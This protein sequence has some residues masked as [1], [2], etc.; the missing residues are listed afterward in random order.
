MHKTLSG[1]SAPN[2][3]RTTAR[4]D[5]TNQTALAG[6]AAPARIMTLDGAVPVDCLRPGDRIVTRDT[7]MCRLVAVTSR[8]HRD[9]TAIN[10]SCSSL[11]HGRPEHGLTLGPGQQVL[12]R[13]WRA[14]ALFGQHTAMVPV[15]RLVDGEFIS[16]RETPMR[17]RLFA[18]DLGGDHVIYVDGLECSSKS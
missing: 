14:L 7:G 9:V 17:L 10:V 1:A 16:R 11:G 4:H 6:F 13:D 8:I 5:K 18:L 3:S 15:E 12:L 2:P